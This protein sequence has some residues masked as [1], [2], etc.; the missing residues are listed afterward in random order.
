MFR[1]QFIHTLDSKGRLSIPA[2]LRKHFSDAANDT[3]VMTQGTETCID[4]YPHDHWQKF[5]E[6][7]R[8][9]NPFDPDEMKFIRMISQHATDD[10][11]DS[12]ARILIPQL[13][14]EH[15]RIEK[16]ILILG[17]MEKIELW[18]PGIFNDYL[19]QSRETYSEV[20]AKVMVTR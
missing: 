3:V 4:V 9:L 17:A 7:M 12:Q 6:N 8:K 11:L 1:G 5:E 14:L 15:A 16:E 19:K 10:K 20:A 2:K 18:N 13:L